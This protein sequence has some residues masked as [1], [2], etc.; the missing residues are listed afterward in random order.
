L[1]ASIAAFILLVALLVPGG[2]RADSASRPR[3]ISAAGTAFRDCD[4]C[5]EMIVVPAGTFTIGSPPDELGRRDDEGPQT[6]IRISR[7]F[8]VGR[9][10]VTRRQYERFLRET[11]HPVSGN[12]MTDRRKPGTWAPDAETN[13]RDPGFR[14][15]DEHP[16]ACVSWND[17]KAYVAWLN[18]T[19]G[20]GY[21]LLTEAE[22]EYVAR[23]GSTS[24]YPW[25]AS[26][27]DGCDHMN[28]YDRTILDKKGDLYR[29]EAVSFANCSDGYLNTSPVGS[30][31][32]NAF[33]VYDMIGNLGEWVED[34]STQSYASI[35]PDG[36]P[37]AGD[38]SKRMVRGGSW[39]TMPRQLRSAERI[40]Y[41]PTAVDDSIGIRV[42]KTLLPASVK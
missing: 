10:E 2:A 17:A 33:G 23:A 28:G 13:V 26:I 27:H 7:P 24:A 40:R 30:Y 38:C 12:C 35:R 25:G 36:S 8:A 3:P 29:G 14:Q 15:T 21:R 41:D 42:A 16:A 22:W 11:N 5:P 37:V 39:G 20:G 32:P 31:K 19:A 34:C 1:N 4:A 9:Y 18:A 6:R